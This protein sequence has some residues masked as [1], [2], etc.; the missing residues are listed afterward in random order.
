MSLPG[1]PLVAASVSSG[2][3]IPPEVLQEVFG[4]RVHQAVMEQAAQ[5]RVVFVQTVLPRGW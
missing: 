1:H 2:Q 3:T 5:Q 4:R